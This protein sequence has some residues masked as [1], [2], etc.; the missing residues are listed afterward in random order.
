MTTTPDSVEGI[1]DTFKWAVLLSKWAGGV[2][3]SISDLRAEGS[4]IR[5]TGGYSDG[6]VPFLRTK[7]ALARYINQSGKR[8]GSFA[9]Y[10]EP[11]HA[12]IEKFLEAK[13]NHGNEE[14]R[15]RDLF[16]GLWIPDLFM[17][18]VENNNKGR[19]LMCPDEC[20]GLTEA[21]GTQFEN[22]YNKYVQQGKYR[23]VINARDLFIQIT[24][25]QRE[26]G[27][28]YML[29]KDAC[30]KRNNQKIL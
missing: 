4:Y 19:Y 20:K 17:K 9:M 14:E 3:Q 28:P 13:K 23:Q 30:N 25:S 6:I 27:L 26:T 1:F 16:Y 11:W 29:Y 21:Y 2:G 12:D 24:T 8:L 22:L 7:N 5:K 18:C 15:A 10:L